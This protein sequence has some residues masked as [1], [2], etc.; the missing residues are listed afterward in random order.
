MLI[1]IAFA[2]LIFMFWVLFLP[3]KYARKISSIFCFVF[4]NMADVIFGLKRRIVGVENIAKHPVIYALKHQSTYETFWFGAVI[5]NSSWIMKKSLMYIPIL[6]LYFWRTGMVPIDRS[7]GRNSILKMIQEAKKIYERDCV[8]SIFPEGTRRP[9]GAKP[10]YKQGAYILYSELNIPVVPVALNTGLYWNRGLWN[11]KK[12]RVTMEFLPEIKPG[13]NKEQFM[14]RLEQDI[15]KA[16]KKLVE[17][18]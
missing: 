15:E 8:I 3:K 18:P 9:L 4:I 13:L 11:G 1:L 10:K 7:K 16:S 6:G 17:K 2:F 5:N 14:K 12:G